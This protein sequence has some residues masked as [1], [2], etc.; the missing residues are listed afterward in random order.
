MTKSA[1][2]RWF[3]IKG[4][5]GEIL[6]LLKNENWKSV[7]IPKKVAFISNFLINLVLLACIQ[8]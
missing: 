8:D 2:Q 1:I 6:L 3:Y 7:L 4:G 5:W